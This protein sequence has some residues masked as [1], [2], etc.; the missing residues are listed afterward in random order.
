[1]FVLYVNDLPELTKSNTFLFADVIKIFRAI[2]NKNDQDI[3][4]QDLSI[5]EQWS[6][7]WLLKFHPDK[8][9]HMEIGKNNIGEN[10]YFMTSN[11]V[12]HSLA[13]TDKHTDLGI[14]IDSKLS[15]DDH[16]NQVV[17]KATKMTKIIRRTFQFLD[18]HT[19]LPLYKTMV[20]SHLEYSVAVWYPYKIKHKIA[21][22]NVQRR[23]TKQLPGMRDLSYIERLKLLKLPTL[24]YRRLR[25]DMIEVYKIMHE[26]YDNESAPN[27][28]KWEDVT[29]RSGNR[30]HCL[31]IF[32]QR[33]KINLRKNAFPHRVAE[34]WN[35]LPNSVIQA[36]SINSFKNKLDKFW[37]TQAII[38]D[39]ES[40]LTIT[41][42][43]RNYDIKIFD[44]EDLIMEE[45][46]GSCDQNRHK[47][48]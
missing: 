28:L 14:I 38:Y 44:S 3:L 17:N 43:T 47:V 24:A 26:L 18:T 42:G 29:L 21:I 12:K 5:L 32:T 25:G 45:S 46:T 2:T 13:T 11:N 20:R 39:Y 1:M 15:F 8:C 4:Q 23:A 30:G 36:R 19:F 35:S 10:E 27:L 33:A 16:I 9:K 7:K 6:D 31:K 48:S 37:S 41:N 22:E 40:P 34:Q